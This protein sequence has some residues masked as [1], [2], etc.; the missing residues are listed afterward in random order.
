VHLG[1]ALVDVEP[2]REEAILLERD[3]QCLL[4]DDRTSGGV[5][6]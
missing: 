4:V 1:L 5:T 6:R 3:R 2:G